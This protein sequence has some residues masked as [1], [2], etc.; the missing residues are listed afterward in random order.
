MESY[1]MRISRAVAAQEVVAERNPF[2]AGATR[3]YL[4]LPKSS[5][6]LA[7]ARHALCSLTA[8]GIVP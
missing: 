5:K 3:S 1:N 6:S 8:G 2:V 7:T 4:H